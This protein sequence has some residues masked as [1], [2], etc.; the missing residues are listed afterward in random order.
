MIGRI[1]FKYARAITSIL[2][3]EFLLTAF[4]WPNGGTVI[5][6][7]SFCISFL[8][9]TLYSLLIQVLD[10]R[11]LL[12]FSAM[13]L[14]LQII[15]GI[16]ILGPVFAAIYLALYSR[17]S[18]QW[19]YLSNLYNQIKQ[20]ETSLEVNKKSLNHWKAGFIE[21]AVELHLALKPMYAMI[22][23]GWSQ[24]PKVKK[25]FKAS[26]PDGEVVF[27]ILMKDVEKRLSQR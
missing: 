14:K 6:I 17:F 4:K 9:I 18:S 26:V 7:R 24:N 20:A 23:K 15:E 25:A 1:F 16:K 27:K 11:R 3:F 12:V 21:D 5:F 2:S 19:G 22:I 13:E 10:P 8:A